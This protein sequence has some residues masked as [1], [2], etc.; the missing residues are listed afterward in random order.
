VTNIS[1]LAGRASACG[2]GPGWELAATRAMAE[3]GRRLADGDPG[4]VR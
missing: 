1:A 3:V 4:L 2:A